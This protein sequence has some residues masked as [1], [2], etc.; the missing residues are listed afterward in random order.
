M[1][2]QRKMA[3]KMHQGKP[4]PD[5]NPKYTHKE[6]RKHVFDVKQLFTD[7]MQPHQTFSEED[8][9]R[10]IYVKTN[11]IKDKLQLEIIAQGINDGV[12]LSCYNPLGKKEYVLSPK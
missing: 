3:D 12:I 5:L 4:L 2:A 1:A 9:R 8:L 11:A 10:E 7:I 6:G